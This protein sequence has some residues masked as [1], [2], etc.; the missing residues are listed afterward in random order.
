MTQVIP[1]EFDSQKVRVVQGDDG[2]SLFVARDIAKAL[3]YAKPEN[4]ID[5]HSEVQRLEA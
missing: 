1:F 4:A 5:R 2:E 3:G